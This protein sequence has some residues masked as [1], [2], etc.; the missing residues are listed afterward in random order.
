MSEDSSYIEESSRDVSPS[1]PSYSHKRSLHKS[2]KHKHR[3]HKLRKQKERKEERKNAKRISSKDTPRG[4]NRSKCPCGHL[5]VQPQCYTNMRTHELFGTELDSKN[6]IIHESNGIQGTR[7][8]RT[9]KHS[10]THP[11]VPAVQTQKEWII[12]SWTRS[13]ARIMSAYI[14]KTHNYEQYLESRV[15]KMKRKKDRQFLESV[16]FPAKTWRYRL[17]ETTVASYRTNAPV[18]CASRSERLGNFSSDIPKRYGTFLK[19]S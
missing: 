19:K 4:F 17:C 1:P 13:R 10:V 16:N 8:T 5:C 6:P 12:T 3:S 15:W 2:D 11:L 9:T 7:P 14:A 18:I